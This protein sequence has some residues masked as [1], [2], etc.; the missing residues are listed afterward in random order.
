VAQEGSEHPT[1][2]DVV[3]PVSVGMEPGG[4]LPFII[5]KDGV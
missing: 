3:M 4:A 1:G 5:G 2:H